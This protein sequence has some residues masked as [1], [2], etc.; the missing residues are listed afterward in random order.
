MPPLA[1]K[2]TA[3]GRVQLVVQGDDFGMCHAVNQGVETCF[4]AGILTQAS[5]MA[6]CPWAEEAFSLA[7]RHRI[8]LGLHQT[9]TCDWEH[10]RWRP[11]TNGR[12]LVG[13]DGMFR[14][15]VAEAAASVVV[16]EAVAELL[17]QADRVT[18]A[19][20]R[21]GY[22]DLH[23][24]P[25]CVPAYEA[26]SNKLGLPFLYPGLASSLRFASI[27]HLS[28]RPAGEKRAWLMSHLAGL[29]LG[30]HLLVCHPG[31]PGPELASVTTPESPVYRWAQEYRASDLEVLTDPEVR[32]AVEQHG[33]VLTSVAQ[34]DFA[35]GSRP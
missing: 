24:G 11:L 34:A 7:R 16:E 28:P 12:S 27:E 20:V 26:V 8:P 1:S 31:V 10:L 5:M 23:M 25:V 19:G 13:A 9:L 35:A 29:F 2:G 21:L 17:A 3:K 14:S 4:T 30:V 32:R 22:L 6:P 33:V 18:S 15:T